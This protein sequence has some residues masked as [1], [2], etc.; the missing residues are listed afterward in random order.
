MIGVNGINSKDFLFGHSHLVTHVFNFLFFVLFFLI[1]K[2][3]L[4]VIFGT[5]KSLVGY[6]NFV[7]PLSGV[8]AFSFL[9]LYM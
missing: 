6:V 7:L 8:G 2:L 1:I 4:S 3:F 9:F 5:S